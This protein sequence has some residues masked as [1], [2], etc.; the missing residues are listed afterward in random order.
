MLMMR[1]TP[2][3]RES[4]AATKNRPEAEARPSTAWNASPSQF[5][6]GRY[7]SPATASS[8]RLYPLL[9][10]AASASGVRR[11]RQ[12]Q[13]RLLRVRLRHQGAAMAVGDCGEASGHVGAE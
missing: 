6:A 13:R 3:I 5:I 1:V 9:A 2:K 8:S 11:M 12:Q 10:G 7:Q 4:P